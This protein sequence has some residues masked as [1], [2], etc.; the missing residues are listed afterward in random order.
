MKH[1][2][3]IKAFIKTLMN[4]ESFHALVVQSPPGWGKSTTIDVALADLAIDA[5]VAGSYATPLH[6]YNTLCRHPDS[7]I[8]FDDCA[9]L[10]S[11]QKSMAI[12][13]AATWQSS[14]QGAT[15]RTSR[16]V[17]WGSTS[18]KAE[19]ASL[20][21][22]GKLILLTNVVPAGKETEA[23]LSRCLSYR[24]NI[25]DDE[26]KQM[27]LSVAASSTH[28][29]KSELALD[30]ARYLVDNS[31]RADLTKLNLRTLKM[32]YDLA[33]THPDAWRELFVYLLPRKSEPSDLISQLLQSGL[34]SKEQEAK[35]VAA[36]GLSRRTFFNQKK[37]LGMTRSYRSKIV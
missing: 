14:G 6:I 29:P 16:R 24:I 1:V 32:G 28:F 18:D 7:M 30:V 37:R 13:K 34:P 33:V 25:G 31:T 4:S 26:V 23:F 12:L 3:T 35:F 2:E 8:I 15:T 19:Q 21:F 9:G 27:L 22:T 36:T 10:F 11:D 20:D 5:V 17:A